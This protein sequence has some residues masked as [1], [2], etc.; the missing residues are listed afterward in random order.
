MGG[1]GL[2][3]WRGIRLGRGRETEREPTAWRNKH[4]A[5]PSPYSWCHSGLNSLPAVL[6]FIK[7]KIN[8]K[9]I[10]S[11][12][13]QEMALQRVSFATTKY[14]FVAGKTTAATT[15]LLPSQINLGEKLSHTKLCSD[16]DRTA[17]RFYRDKWLLSFAICKYLQTCVCSD[18]CR[19]NAHF[20]ATNLMLS[21]Q[22][23]NSGGD[24]RWWWTNRAAD[25]R[26][27]WSRMSAAAKTTLESLCFCQPR[28]GM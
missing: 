9:E 18:F 7:Y 2:F 23:S 13:R 24:R 11:L 22:V 4:L 14:T 20:A 15:L 27:E 21:Q 12:Q 26:P 3:V 8:L 17:S 28:L 6:T 19:R 16:T 1:L 5:L 25:D 10:E